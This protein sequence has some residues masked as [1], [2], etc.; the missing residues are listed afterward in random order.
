MQR[1][2][3]IFIRG[4]QVLATL[5]I[6]YGLLR[7]AAGT[8][9]WLWMWVFLLLYV[10]GILYVSQF[11]LR[12]IPDTIARRSEANDAKGWDRIVG[13][14]WTLSHFILLPLIAGLDFHFGWSAGYP[15]VLHEFG[16]IVFVLGFAIF[17]WAL[18]ENAFFSTVVR[19]QTKQ[20]Q[21]VCSSGPYE[22]A[23][24]PGYTGA[25]LQSLGT[26]MILGSWWGLGIAALSIVLLVWRTELED[27]TL[28]K[29]LPGYHAFANKVKYRLLPHLW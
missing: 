7:L 24:H 13:G 18:Y 26:A 6:Q 23:R 19:V 28:Q 4:L 10:G 9:L 5:L 1:N 20:G 17:S 8:R 21:N 22:F 3:K 27:E 29:E 12:H 2:K 16:I 15:L 11:F 14:L 25:C